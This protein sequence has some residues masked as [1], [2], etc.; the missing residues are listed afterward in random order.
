MKWPPNKYFKQK[1]KSTSNKDLSRQGKT[2]FYTFIV[3]MK[4]KLFFFC[5][6]K[7]FMILLSFLDIFSHP[8]LQSLTRNYLTTLHA[9]HRFLEHNRC[10]LI[11]TI[12]INRGYL[13]NHTF[14]MLTLTK[15]SITTK[16]GITILGLQEDSDKHNSI[17]SKMYV[18]YIFVIVYEY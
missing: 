12:T 11:E 16:I 6:L 8:S 10:G 5:N 1:L 3:I 14:R 15:I 9:I 18:F 17:N 4:K 7:S 2:F 13:D